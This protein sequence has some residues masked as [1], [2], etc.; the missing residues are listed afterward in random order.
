MLFLLMGALSMP[1]IAAT[2]RL[3]E[4]FMYEQPPSTQSGNVVRPR[5]EWAGIKL[6]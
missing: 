6:P 4:A 2:D 1:K 5:H 3:F